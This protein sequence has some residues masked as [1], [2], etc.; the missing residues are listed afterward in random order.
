MIVDLTGKR[1]IVTGATSGIGFVI[2]RGLAA[3]AAAVMRS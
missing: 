1:A 2:A 3:T